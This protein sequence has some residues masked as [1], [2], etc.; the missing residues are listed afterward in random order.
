M[1]A[2]RDLRVESRPLIRVD[3][4]VQEH[5]DVEVAFSVGAT[6][7]DASEDIGRHN[8]RN[9]IAGQHLPYPVD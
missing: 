4:T 3:L 8:T 2:Q 1:A 7:R 5:A 6:L 9:R